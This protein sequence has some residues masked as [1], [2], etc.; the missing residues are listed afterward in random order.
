M[1]DMPLYWPQITR[2]PVGCRATGFVQVTHM[3]ANR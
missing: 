2:P 1:I 3:V